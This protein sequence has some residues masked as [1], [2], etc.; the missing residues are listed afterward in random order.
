MEF[1]NN[2]LLKDGK[3]PKPNFWRAV[4]DNDFGNKMQVKNIEWKKASLFSEVTEVISNQLSAN[5]VELRVKKEEMSN[6]LSRLL[7]PADVEINI[8]G[9]FKK[10]RD[11]RVNKLTRLKNTGDEFKKHAVGLRVIKYDAIK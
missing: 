3:G 11:E 6:K 2:E 9:R 10:S 4:T 8:L 1:K 7:N 5:E